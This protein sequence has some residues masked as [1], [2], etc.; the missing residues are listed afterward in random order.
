MRPTVRSS[1]PYVSSASHDC[2]TH[3]VP[4]AVNENMSWCGTAP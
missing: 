2:A 3:F 4:G 1:A